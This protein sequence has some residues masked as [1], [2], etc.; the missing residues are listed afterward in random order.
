[1]I[2]VTKCNNQT[3]VQLPEGV[4]CKKGDKIPCPAACKLKNGICSK[5]TTF[6]ALFVRQTDEN[7]ATIAVKYSDDELKTLWG[8]DSA[9]KADV[10]QKAESAQIEDNL[11]RPT[12][13]ARPMSF[14][15][16]R[17]PQREAETAVD[18]TLKP[19]RTYDSFQCR[20][21]VYSDDVNIRMQRNAQPLRNALMTIFLRWETQLV[22]A[23]STTLKDEFVW[24]LTET[25]QRSFTKSEI[26]AILLNDAYGISEKFFYLFYDIIF[27]Y[28]PIRGFYWCD[29]PIAPTQLTA[30]F[31]DRQDFVIKYCSV[32]TRGEQFRK[33]Y[34][35]R[36]KEILHFLGCDSEERLFEDM[37]LLISRDRRRVVL[38]DQYDGYNPIDLGTVTEFISNMQHPTDLPNME[39]MVAFLRKYQLRR[40]GVIERRVANEPLQEFSRGD[41][42]EDVSMYD[43]LS[44][45]STT[46]CATEY[47]RFVT[48]LHEYVITFNPSEVKIGD[49]TFTR[50]HFSAEI[51][52]IV[53]NL[54]KTE[55]GREVSPDAKK[56]AK[57]LAWLAKSIYERG[58]LS[59][60]TVENGAVIDALMQLIAQPTQER[61][62]AL[63]GENAVIQ[64]GNEDLSV[65]KYIAQ[66]MEDDIFTICGR[67]SQDETAVAFFKQVDKSRLDTTM[68]RLFENYQQQYDTAFKS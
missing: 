61:Y 23:T 37:T 60:F 49:I 41:L 35:L 10:S 7:S 54:C 57:G 28:D 3:C 40:N 16:S 42:T 52:E 59:T 31:K 15:Q 55:F 4:A 66:L 11:S 26:D 44:L 65:R 32:D 64:V 27:R 30:Y 38:I 50:R 13:G 12:G 14:G 53:Q 5:I 19:Q 8:I 24:L 36:K 46:R 1:M 20:Y 58:I 17:R 56:H 29:R 63:F 67:F 39:K 34:Q 22:F 33:F 21:G 51:E 25:S 43:T 2:C 6:S 62:L 18:E 9:P 47:D 48:L 45:G 68:N